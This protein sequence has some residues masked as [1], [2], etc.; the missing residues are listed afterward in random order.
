MKPPLF[1]QTIAEY[2]CSKRCG[3]HRSAA[4]ANL[5]FFHLAAAV[6]AAVPLWIRLL[7]KPWS[8]PWYYLP[9]II[10]G[11][12]LL[13]IFCG[14]ASGIVVNPIAS[15][16]TTICKNCRAAMMFCGRHFDPKGSQKP[17]WSDIVIFLMF[18]A[19]NVALWLALVRG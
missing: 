1:Q 10:A 2:V 4:G 13:L 19:S 5:A 14:L 3:Y 17:H 9:S 6:V 18:L 7:A 12:L 11:E 8:F 15:A 16:G